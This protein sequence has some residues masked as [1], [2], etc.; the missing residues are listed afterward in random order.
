MSAR[1]APS[2][3][4]KPFLPDRLSADMQSCG[5]L[6]WSS[7][8]FGKHPVAGLM[9]KQTSYQPP[10]LLLPSPLALQAIR[11]W[12]WQFHRP[13]SGRSSAFCLALHSECLIPCSP[14]NPGCLLSVNTSMEPLSLLHRSC[15]TFLCLCLQAL[16]ATSVYTETPQTG[17]SLCPRRLRR[18]CSHTPQITNCYPRGSYI[19]LS[20]TLPTV[21][22]PGY[23]RCEENILR[24]S[25]LEN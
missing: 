20:L 18:P 22:R 3:G 8:A 15:S 19:S 1:Y 5:G 17:P 14:L 7:A 13:G 4:T 23:R 2:T 24:G 25:C 12:L 11:C 6:G 9:G 21:S 16:G 10:L